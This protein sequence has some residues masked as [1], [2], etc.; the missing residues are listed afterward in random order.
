MDNADIARRFSE[1]PGFELV[2]Y[3]EAALPLF[4]MNLEVLVLE[5]ED[6][7]P[8]QEFVLRA[9]AAG[10][11][12][13]ESIHGFLG[14]QEAVV[15]RA[16]AALMHS[17]DLV[18]T[19]GAAEDRRHRMAL[20]RKGSKTVEAAQLVQAV[21]LP[22]PVFVD[23][24]TR[25]IVS[26]TGR[27]LHA[28]RASIAADRGL[29]EI[30]ASPRRKPRFEEI[31]ADEVKSMLVRETL[32]RR[33]RREIVGVVGVGRTTRFAR[34][35]LALAFRAKKGGEMQV[36]FVVD[37]RLSE[38]H[39]AAFERAQSNSLRVL[40]PELWKDAERVIAE[41]L[42][43]GVHK[44]AAPR[45]ESIELDR[46]RADAALKR[47]E[48]RDARSDEDGAETLRVR[49]EE[50]ERREREALEALNA[51]SVRHVEVYAHR[52]YLDRA[53]D[54]ATARLMIISPWIRAEVVDKEFVAKL[55][56]V[57]DRGTQLYIGY[58]FGPDDGGQRPPRLVKRD[59]QAEQDLRRLSSQYQN[60]HFARL[61]DTHAKVLICDSLF[62]IVTSFNWL[63]F[64]GDRRLQFRDERGM[65]VGIPSTVD[66]LFASYA[67]RFDAE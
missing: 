54:E 56:N 13:I 48:L 55:R 8:I 61:G 28:Y 46:I 63:S 20:T 49:V 32:G 58:G 19:G 47:Q 60:F 30:P 2:S 59:K 35:A 24:L 9:V 1:R 65:Y 57:L 37:G 14:I 11:T 41:A 50:A 4:R 5:A 66:D 21:E 16:A 10:L 36:S 42:P 44:S 45:E 29:V 3:R 25:R 52:E 22:I 62:S 67:A 33:S 18:L 26:V 39:D 7:P 64:R 43:P 6:V 40:A 34:D 38:A 12:D 17:D 31:P 27:G 23:G 15:T 53:L 51:L